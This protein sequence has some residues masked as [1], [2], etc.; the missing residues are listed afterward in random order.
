M[1]SLIAGVILIHSF[2]SHG[3]DLGG[4]IT[5]NTV[6]DKSGNPYHVTND[7]VVEKDVILTIGPGVEVVMSTDKSLRGSGTI[8]IAGSV[9]QRAIIRSETPTNVWRSITVTG[10][11]ASLNIR[12]ADIS[13]G[14]VQFGP[15]ST[16]MIEDS[17]IHD[18]NN[19]STPIA[20]AAAA[21]GVT[22]RRA[23]FQNYYETLWQETMMLIEDSLFEYASRT[24]SDALDFDTAPPGSTI[25]RCTFR[26]GSKQNTDAIDLG[27][28]SRGVIVEDCLIYD[29]PSDKGIS[30]GEDSF[31][32]VVRNTVIQGCNSGIAV[33]DSCTATVTGCTIVG[34]DYGIRNYNKADP[35]A[36]TGG[37]HI[38]EACNNLLWGNQLTVSLSNG[39][40]FVADHSLISGTNWPG[41]GNIDLDPSFVNLAASDLRLKSDSPGMSAGRNGAQVGGYFPLGTKIAASHPGFVQQRQVRD[42][43]SLL[44]WVDPEKSYTVTVSSSLSGRWMELTN[45]AT[46]TGPELREMKFPVVPGANFFQVR[47]TTRNSP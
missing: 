45:I 46:E 7:I 26:H 3:A 35:A 36:L 16:G 17:F 40:T 10:T 25:R 6:W 24:N 39:S 43:V 27:S 30:I 9:D 42:Q 1:R 47:A 41:P 20:H 15:G 33:K 44:L 21:S 28:R 2:L 5:S 31:E 38:T 29:F 11:N 18:F 34:N 13:G 8:D 12:F 22:V 23:H 4:P 19:G 37:G 32:I 14:S